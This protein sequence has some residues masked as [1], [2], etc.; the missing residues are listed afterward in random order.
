[1]DLKLSKF[2]KVMGNHIFCCFKMFSESNLHTFGWHAFLRLFIR[3]ISPENA[4]REILKLGVIFSRCRS[5]E[6]RRE[7]GL[8]SFI[9]NSAAYEIELEAE[10]WKACLTWFERRTKATGQT[11]N[12]TYFDHKASA[13]TALEHLSA[14]ALW[15]HLLT[16][17]SLQYWALYV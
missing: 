8:W 12:K 3:D 2:F 13:G 6:N 10:S 17:P 15:A 14:F 5:K 9:E 16:V 11:W 7:Q 4:W 1:M